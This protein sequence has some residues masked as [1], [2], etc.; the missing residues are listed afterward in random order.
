MCRSKV[1]Y[2]KMW[3]HDLEWTTAPCRCWDNP[4]IRPQTMFLRAK[5]GRLTMPSHSMGC[6]LN[7]LQSLQTQL[8]AGGTKCLMVTDRKK[9]IK[10]NPQAFIFGKP[11]TIL[12]AAI[13]NPV[14][15]SSSNNSTVKCF[16]VHLAMEETG[17]VNFNWLWVTAHFGFQD[18]VIYSPVKLHLAITQ[19]IS[20]WC[21]SVEISFFELYFHFDAGPVLM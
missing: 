17:R 9:C 15:G 2:N 4:A 13:E 12:I 7:Q 16:H 10:K 6:A 3:D 11:L 19:T 21:L 14:N 8:S 5:P 1:D 20:V 18:A